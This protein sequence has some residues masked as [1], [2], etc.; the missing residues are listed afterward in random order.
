MKYYKIIGL[1]PNIDFDYIMINESEERR[2]YLL[3][4]CEISNDTFTFDK[5]GKPKQF[6]EFELKDE[7]IYDED[8]FNILNSK[9]KDLDEEVNY[10]KSLN[11][12]LYSV[13]SDDLAFSVMRK[14]DEIN[15]IL[16]DEYLKEVLHNK[17]KDN[18]SRVVENLGDE[19]V[20]KYFNS[21]S[22]KREFNNSIV[23][24][25]LVKYDPLVNTERLKTIIQD[26]DFNKEEDK[27]KAIEAL[28]QQIKED[29]NN[30]TIDINIKKLVKENP[31]FFDLD[32]LIK[33]EEKAIL[34]IFQEVELEKDNQLIKIEVDHQQDITKE[35]IEEMIR[36]AEE[37]RYKDRPDDPDFGNGQFTEEEINRRSET[38][39]EE[40]KLQEREETKENERPIVYDHIFE[41]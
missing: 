3:Q 40:K 4:Q 33:G 35:I 41:L 32:K 24:D 28:D 8:L 18:W 6:N 20:L 37:K 27:L 25:D 5:G 15:F 29:L 21:S 7:E 26:F 2:L 10:N 1:D 38:E 17:V 19:T 23:A 9:Y 11:K 34:A 12:Y 13:K 16:E 22:F 14:E 30:T 36:Q 31:N 39:I